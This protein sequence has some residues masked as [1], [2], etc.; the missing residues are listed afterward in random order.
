MKFPIALVA[1]SSSV[2]AG[3][4]AL[5]TRNGRK[6]MEGGTIVGSRME[7]DYGIEDDC[8]I[9]PY[10]QLSE[11]ATCE[12]VLSGTNTNS[13]YENNNFLCRTAE[14]PCDA[15]ENSSWNFEAGD[16]GDLVIDLGNNGVLSFSED[17]DGELGSP[18][19][20]VLLAD[21]EG[22]PVDGTDFDEC[23]RFSS[24]GIIFSSENGYSGG[25]VNDYEFGSLECCSDYD[26][27]ARVYIVIDGVVVDS[28]PP[29]VAEG[30][31]NCVVGR[32]GSS[33]KTISE[34]SKSSKKS[35]TEKVS[36][37]A[38]FLVSYDFHNASSIVA[39]SLDYTRSNQR[40]RPR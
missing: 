31:R 8:G 1:I 26:S 28:C 5:N 38:K 34:S 36:S 19:V 12:K 30:C 21:D 10:E 2:S 33:S 9:N 24:E 11:P 17:E 37:V 29:A 4:N 27:D 39:R 22:N 23:F 7:K 40:A 35:T 20:W 25:D 6:L 13:Y 16:S 18:E 3:V 14:R 32:V 15:D